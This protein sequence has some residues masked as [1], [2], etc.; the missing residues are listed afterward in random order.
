M[1][2]FL[3]FILFCIIIYATLTIYKQ[4]IDNAYLKPFEE[5]FKAMDMAANL[6]IA[7]IIIITIAYEF[8]IKS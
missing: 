5:S 3:S 4:S 7:F 2:L 8:M 6:G 1:L